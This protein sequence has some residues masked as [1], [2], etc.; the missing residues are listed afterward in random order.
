MVLLICYILKTSQSQKINQVDLS[1]REKLDRILSCV[2]PVTCWF[3][4]PS[5]VLNLGSE[6]AGGCAPHTPSYQRVFCVFDAWKILRQGQAPT[7]GLLRYHEGRT[8][9]P[10]K[11]FYKT[12]YESLT[13]RRTPFRGPCTVMHGKLERLRRVVGE[14]APRK[15]KERVGCG[16]RFPVR[17]SKVGPCKDTHTTQGALCCEMLLPQQATSKICPLYTFRGFF[18][19]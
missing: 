6:R 8:G 9:E 19:T 14:K 17:C 18:F 11:R 4:V 12:E 16:R 7:S 5:L 1:E 10:E 2:F 3:F 15:K 13:N